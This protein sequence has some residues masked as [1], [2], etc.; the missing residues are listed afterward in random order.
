MCPRCFVSLQVLRLCDPSSICFGSCAKKTLELYHVIFFFRM[1]MDLS[2]SSQAPVIVCMD[3][4]VSGHD[5]LHPLQLILLS[6]R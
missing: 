3:S 6:A 2:S 5:S 4:K 1:I